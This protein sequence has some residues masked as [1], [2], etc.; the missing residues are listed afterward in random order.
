MKE[1]EHYNIWLGKNGGC[2]RSRT[3]ESYKVFKII[4]LAKDSFVKF[5]RFN[6]NNPAP[7]ILVKLSSKIYSS[8]NK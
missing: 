7:P 5:K 4:N 8:E 1:T 2:E 6:T 3:K